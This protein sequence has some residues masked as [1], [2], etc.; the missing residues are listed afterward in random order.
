MNDV[1][2]KVDTA[3]GKM[4]DQAKSQQDAQKAL[5]YSQAALNLAHTMSI[6]A[7]QKPA[8]SNVVGKQETKKDA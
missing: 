7:N 5:H 8:T 4:A 2:E 3:L 1:I 6:L